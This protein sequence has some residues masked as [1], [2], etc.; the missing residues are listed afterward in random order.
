MFKICLSSTPFT[1]DAANG[2][3]QNIKGD[4]FSGDNTFLA[5]LRALVA[6][7]IS[8]NESVSLRFGSSNYNSN[9]INNAPTRDVVGA[10]CSGYDM[11]KPGQLIIH[12]LRSDQASN[13]LCLEKIEEKFCSMYEGYH[14]FDKV[15][16]FYRKSFNVD[17]YVNPEIKSVI[18][19]VDNLDYRKL[20]YLQV[21]VLVFLPW[22][23]NQQDG[24]TQDEMALIQSLRET[25]PDNYERCLSKL[26][27]QYDFRTA[28]IRQLL[29][30]FESRYERIECEKIQQDIEGIDAQINRLNNQIGD[31][32]SRR[33]DSCIRLLGLE[34]KI[35]KGGEDSEIMEYFL[36]NERLVLEQVTDR[37]MYFCVKDYLEYF[38]KEMAERA[39]NNMSSFV[40]QADGRRL[41]TGD[42]AE[43]M[44]KLMTEIF[45]SDNPRLRIKICA[46][47]R[48][49]LNGSV[50]P[51]GG[52]D[53]G[54]E[55]AGYLPNP[56]INRYNCMGNYLTTINELLRN[57]DYIGAL[58]QCIA[59]CKS[60]NWGDGAVMSHFMGTMW[61]NG[62]DNRCI[63]LPDGNVVTPN[64]A[65]K[66]LEQ[67]EMETNEQTEEAQTNE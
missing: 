5:T 44:K 45:V 58:E 41:R 23:L 9:A 64:E 40:Y 14:Y 46:A 11:T 57:R 29:S 49:D 6:P 16:A 15:K 55:F 33:N 48:F 60:L 66:W 61:G 24:L 39:I 28:R 21:S 1:T 27:E 50:G 25:S 35:A 18:V 63:E 17:C 54:C 37:D 51:N 4:S 30:G 38:D 10:V 26:A 62:A 3:F 12:N 22:Y 52:H 67:Q 34:Q 43:K 7:R 59:S 20:H 56:H 42:A 65:I 47:Y 32:L 19:F 8:E 2:Y 53:F 36:C 13:L 31:Y